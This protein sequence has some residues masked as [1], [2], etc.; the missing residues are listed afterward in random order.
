MKHQSMRQNG[1]L[2]RK[3]NGLQREEAGSGEG[4]TEQAPGRTLLQD[5]AQE[6]LAWVGSW[7]PYP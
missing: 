4:S 1:L 3:V 6:A 7:T 5:M 2:S